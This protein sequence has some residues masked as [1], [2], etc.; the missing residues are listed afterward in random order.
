MKFL[1]TLSMLFSFAFIGCA[2]KPVATSSTHCED[3]CDRDHKDGK[4][5]N[6][7]NDKDK[8]ETKDKKK[9]KG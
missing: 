3:G 1:V 6:C 2:N 9:K 4:D 7:C 8:K 5:Q